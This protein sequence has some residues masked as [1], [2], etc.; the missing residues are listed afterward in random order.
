MILMVFPY[1]WAPALAHILTRLITGEGWK[2]LSLQ[3]HF[4]KGWFYWVLA[5]FV[6]VLM[7]VF[8][9]V[10]FFILFPVYFSPELALSQIPASIIS[11]PIFAHGSFW[12]I[13]ALG[14]L[15]AT[16]ISPLLNSWATFGEEFGWRAYHL[17]K[18]LPLGWRKAV[19][20]SGII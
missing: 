3:P 9:A 18:P 2:D 20:L 19:L 7:T 5:W 12:I 1:M 16:L 15:A 11:L 13:V 14:I 8:G 6:P 17:P 10:V 4:R